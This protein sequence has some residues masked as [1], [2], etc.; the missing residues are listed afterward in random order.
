M[1]S[2]AANNVMPRR[3]VRNK[4]KIRSSPGPRIGV[5]C[6]AANNARI[7]NEG[8]TTF[9]F[10]T[11][12]GVQTQFVFQITE[13]NKALGAVS[14]MVDHRHKVVFDQYKQGKDMSDML[15]KPSGDIFKLRRERNVWVLDAMVE[16]DSYFGKCVNGFANKA[17]DFASQA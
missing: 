3:M 10:H 9:K 12:E 8:E 15:H 7:L 1:N 11:N 17:E 13:V 5:H 2:G 14:Y 16:E 4:T 6:V